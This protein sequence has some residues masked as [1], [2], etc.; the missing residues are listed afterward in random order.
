L[1][2]R[3]AIREGLSKKQRKERRGLAIAGEIEG[4]YGK[5]GTKLE[6]WQHLCRDVKIEPIP[7]SVTQCKKVRGVGVCRRALADTRMVL[8]AQVSL[9]Q[10]R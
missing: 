6:N 1:F 9:G 8:G 3:L 2:N 5:D 7:P 4:I 10:Y